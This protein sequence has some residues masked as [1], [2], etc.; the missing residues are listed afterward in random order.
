MIEYEFRLK[1][2]AMES[3]THQLSAGALMFGCSVKG[4]NGSQ[5]IGFLLGTFNNVGTATC[6]YKKYTGAL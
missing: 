4:G 2:Q 1:P 5:Y 3:L 6:T